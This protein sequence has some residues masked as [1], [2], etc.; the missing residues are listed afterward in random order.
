MRLHL[1]SHTHEPIFISLETNIMLQQPSS[2]LQ[3]PSTRSYKDP[4][5]LLQPPIDTVLHRLP[6]NYA[7]SCRPLINYPCTLCCRPTS[8][9]CSRCQKSW[10]CSPEHLQSVSEIDS[11]SVLL[12]LTHLIGLAS[13]S[14]RMPSCEQPEQ[15]DC[16]TSSRRAS[17]N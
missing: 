17:S 16:H 3:P 6:S 12:S 5:H 4:T 15:Y 9:W 13:S 11:P 1:S 7:M 8:M 2:G 10:Y 14:E